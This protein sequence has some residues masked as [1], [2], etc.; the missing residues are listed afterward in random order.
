MGIKSAYPWFTGNP[1]EFK[2]LESEL[3][4]DR[5]VLVFPNEEKAVGAPWYENDKRYRSSVWRVEDGAPVSL[6]YKKFVNFEE[7]PDFEPVDL[8]DK[9]T[10]IEKIDGTCLI[11]S[12]YKGEYIFRT[13]GTMDV[14]LMENAREVDALAE[15]YRIRELLDGFGGTRTILFEWVTPTNVLCVRYPKPELYLTGI[16]NHAD[17]SYMKQGE[18][19]D[20]A[21]KNGL[22]RPNHHAFKVDD[23]HAMAR[24]IRETWV[25]VEGVV[26]YFGEGEQ[27][28]KKMKSE[29]HRRLH[30]ARILFGSPRRIMNFLIERNAFDAGG[31]E[32]FERFLSN[33]LEFEVYDCFR[34]SFSAAWDAFVRFGENMAA[35]QKI[36]EGTE[37]AREVAGLVAA[38]KT[39]GLN[40]TYVW[41]AFRKKPVRKSFLRS[42]LLS[43]Y[44]ADA[45]GELSAED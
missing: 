22:L 30:A 15:A 9:I 29:W 42:E 38:G 24:V 17:Y 1:D 4:G 44:G 39:G 6:G 18:L 33:E 14:H 10:A 27:L 8:H 3:A 34:E 21:A 2:F 20:F 19:D 36:V 12:K 7:Q 37:D 25:G 26:A 45:D 43:F 41:S 31:R 11:C 35:A 32:S 5:V 28:L 13:R 16:V 40:P 23:A